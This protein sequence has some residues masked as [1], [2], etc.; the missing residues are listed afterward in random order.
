MRSCMTSRS[1]RWR[2]QV[3]PPPEATGIRGQGRNYSSGGTQELRAG[4]ELRTGAARYSPLSTQ[5]GHQALVNTRR[6]SNRAAICLFAVI[7]GIFFTADNL[8]SR[9]V[10]GPENFSAMMILL[11]VVVTMVIATAGFGFGIL[12]S[13]AQHTVRSAV[14]SAGGTWVVSTSAF[15]YFLSTNPTM[16][17]MTA[18]L[19]AALIPL[20]F[21]WFAA[22]TASPSGAEPE[23]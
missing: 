4:L 9:R 7:V 3:T 14:T 2:W 8:W 22:G 5:S 19:S 23:R 21:G 11:D 18:V 12:R 15:R 20:L 10:H 6:L 17:L 1:G 13:K 16:A